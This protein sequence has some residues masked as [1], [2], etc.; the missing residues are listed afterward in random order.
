MVGDDDK[1]VEIDE[2]VESELV[3]DGDMDRV[4]HGD[5]EYEAEA[6]SLV[7]AEADCK[8]DD[9]NNPE[10]VDEIVCVIESV[11]D[12]VCDREC[13]SLDDALKDTDAVSLELRT[14]D[15]E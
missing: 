10:N 13:V 2:D 9:V 12:D 8:N 14:A 15:G 11:P 3:H 5:A 4:L 1:V 6:V 7:V